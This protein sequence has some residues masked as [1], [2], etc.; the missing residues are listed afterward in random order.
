MVQLER[1]IANEIADDVFRKL[2]SAMQYPEFGIGGVPV[3]VA[4]KVFGKGKP[5]VIEG[6]ESGRLTI[7]TVA[8]EKVKGNVYISPKLLW[9][10]TGYVWKGEKAC[11]M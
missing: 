2:Q 5:Y 8:R 4:A 9:E 10:Y 1:E 7:G 6:I 11:E 3:E